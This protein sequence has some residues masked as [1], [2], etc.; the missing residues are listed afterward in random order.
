MCKDVEIMCSEV[1][2]ILSYCMDEFMAG[3]HV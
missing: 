1:Y 2:R 3:N